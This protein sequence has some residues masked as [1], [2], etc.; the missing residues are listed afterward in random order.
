[1]RHLMLL[2][3]ALLLLFAGD[4]GAGAADHAVHQ[5]GRIF[6]VSELTVARYEQVT[7]VNDDTVPHNIMST[8]ADNGFDLGSQSPG[9]ATPVSFS[10]AGVVVV[11]C[12]IHPRM[13]MT[14]TVT[15]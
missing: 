3:A 9:S 15:D 13:Q 2:S 7:F 10:V 8:S 11:I 14:I 6:S 12:A 1:M 5:K 4:D